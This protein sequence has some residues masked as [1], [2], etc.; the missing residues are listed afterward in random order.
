MVF[1]AIAIGG[2]IFQNIFLNFNDGVVCD[3]DGA[4]KS[5]YA[6]INAILE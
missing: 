5:D 1:V 2:D 6:G 3:F 4:K